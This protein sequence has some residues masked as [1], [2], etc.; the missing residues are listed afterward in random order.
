MMTSLALALALTA[1]EPQGTSPYAVNWVFDTTLTLSS[2]SMVYLMHEVAGKSLD[3]D[4]I[5]SEAHP[6]TPCDPSTLPGIDRGTVGKHSKTWDN[7]G[8]YGFYAI[9]GGAALGAALDNGLSGGTGRFR[10]F[11]ADTIVIME[12]TGLAVATAHAIRFGI[13]R[14]RPTQYEGGADVQMSDLERHLSFPSGHSTS[15]AAIATAFATTYWL[16]HPDD[17][18]RWFVA[19]GS[20]AAATLAGFGRVGAGRHFPS[21]AIAG[22]VIGTAFGILI[23]LAHE[24][25]LNV[26]VSTGDSKTINVSGTF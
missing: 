17:P 18:S 25:N 9:I 16:H 20:F 12:S 19:G 23:P 21:D 11:A 2:F 22:Q 5:C 8:N 15:S 3:N 14:P 1:F 10:G 13:R 7:V 26:A 4:Y 6:D 24:A